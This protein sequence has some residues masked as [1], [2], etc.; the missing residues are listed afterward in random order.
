MRTYPTYELKRCNDHSICLNIKSSRQRMRNPRQTR[1]LSRVNSSSSALNAET[2]DQKAER[3]HSS[4][5]RRQRS[6]SVPIASIPDTKS[7]R[8]WSMSSSTPTMYDLFIIAPVFLLDSC[9]FQ[10]TVRQMDITKPSTLACRCVLDLDP[11]SLLSSDS[12]N[13]RSEIRAA[14]ESECYE[15]VNLLHHLLPEV[16]FFK[17]AALWS[18]RRCVRAHAIRSTTV[19]DVLLEPRGAT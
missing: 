6:S 9:H 14:R 12:I 13:V 19:R 18:N 16:E 7:Q 2:T 15:K 3:G 8:A 1:M 4:P 11:A 17:R 10:F 5:R